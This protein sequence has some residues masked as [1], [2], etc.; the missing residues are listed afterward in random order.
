MP[1]TTLRKPLLPSHYSLWFDPPDEAGDEVLHVVS[2][3]RA[4]KL[5][6]RAFREFTKQ[7]VPLLDGRHTIE[8]IQARTEHVFQP[9]DLAD[10]V[11]V[12]HAQGILVDADQSGRPDDVSAR[13][14]PQLNFLHELAPGIDLQ[15]RLD[16]ATVAVVGLT[17]AGATTALMLA[18][19]GVGTVRCVDPEPVSAT[20]VYLSPFLDLGSVGAPR[21]STLTRVLRGSSPQVNAQAVDDPLQS[22]DEVR[23]AIAGADFVVCCLD[24]GQS[25]LIYKLNRVCLAAN[26]R[27][28]TCALAGA[29]IVIG[30]GIHPGKSACYMCYRMRTVACAGSPEQAF[31]Y[32]RYL[33]RKKHDDSGRRENVVF[34]ASIAAGFL[35]TEVLKELTG[36]A[37][38]SFTGRLLTIRLTD[39]LIERHTVLRKPWCP[40]CFPGAAGDGR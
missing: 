22:E 8:E 23:N 13:L 3:R 14:R 35:G 7:V 37:E 34:S 21:A 10:C 15:S 38:P 1:T 18:A 27:W 5:K 16:E 24:A 4:I 11:E 20:D 32:E 17:G 25:N 2:E 31:A 26:M 6:G 36:V 12:L 39:M 9:Q 33:D 19:S 40:A 29:E 30:P 28:L